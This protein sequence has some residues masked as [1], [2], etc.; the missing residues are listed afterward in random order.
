MSNMLRLPQAANLKAAMRQRNPR[1]S[2]K[3]IGLNLNYTT[4]HKCHLWKFLLASY[5]SDWLDPIIPMI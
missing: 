1:I 5:G 2:E 3:Y 4:L